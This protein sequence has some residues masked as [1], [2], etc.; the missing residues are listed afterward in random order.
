MSENIDKSK[1]IENENLQIQT[2]GKRIFN[3]QTV[4]EYLL[5]FLVVFLG[6]SNKDSTEIGFAKCLNEMRSI[7]YTKNPNIGLKRFIFF[8]KTKVDSRFQVDIEANNKINEILT[9][10]IESTNYSSENVLHIIKN[11]LYGFSMVTRNRGW[12]AQSLMPICRDVVF[13]EAI[14]SK[15]KRKNM[16]FLENG[17]IN[18]DTDVEFEFNQY[19]FQARGGEVYFLHL[20]QGLN[21]IKDE[22]GEEKAIFYQKE[23]DS[24]ILMLIDSYKDLGNITN[25]IQKTWIDYIEDSVDPEIEN[26]EKELIEN[27]TCQWI[28]DEYKRRSKY[29]VYEIINLLKTDINQFDKIN[30]LSKGIVLQILRMMSEASYIQSRNDT[31]GNNRSW[32][33]HFVTNGEADLKIKRLAVEV[34]KE[35]EE[36]IMIALS[37]KL[38]NI[39]SNEVLNVQD[40]KTQKSEIQLLKD[41]Y[42]DSYKLLRKLGKDIGIITPIKGDNMRF[43]L[44][45]DIIR[46]LILSTIPPASKMT[47]ETFIDKLYRNFGIIIGPKQ[48]NENASNRGLNFGSAAYLSY[49]LSQFQAI[50]KRNGFL[51]ELSDATAMVINPYN[52]IKGVESI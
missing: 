7:P 29:S 51:K 36:D 26:I 5:E 14:G 17:Y 33:T 16:N 52:E 10:K 2:Y 4:P 22:K 40:K 38:N 15:S 37:N 18:L 43:T 46:F 21:L 27:G 34:Y 49:N 50:L 31:N 9:K 45:D 1:K 19:A 6:K 30:L 13:C 44:S 41:A 28:R 48:F 24:L 23:L 25:W 8:D 12:F 42:D 32:V 39:K 3:S 35:V 11:L 47:L 20:Q